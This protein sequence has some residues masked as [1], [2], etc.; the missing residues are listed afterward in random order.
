MPVDQLIGGIKAD[1][2]HFCQLLYGQ[3][4]G[5][6]I[7]QHTSLKRL[8]GAVGEHLPNTVIDTAQK[9]VIAGRFFPLHNGV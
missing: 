8:I 3:Y 7:Q 2:Q 5:I 1:I 6:V 4:I 9:S